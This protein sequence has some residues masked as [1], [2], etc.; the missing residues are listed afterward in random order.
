MR[1]FIC[2]F[3]LLFLSI[4]LN[5]ALWG[6]ILELGK[7]ITGLPVITQ[8]NA[9]EVGRVEDLGINIKLGTLEGIIIE[10]GTLFRNAKFV[11]INDIVT[12][13]RDVVVITRP[14]AVIDLPHNT[15]QD[16]SW[17]QS[18][19]KSIITTF[20]TDIGIIKDVIIQFPDGKI[21][22]IEI[23]GGIWSD[24]IQGRKIIPLNTVVSGEHQHLIVDNDLENIWL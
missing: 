24:L 23:S 19:G 13:G 21:V 11:S 15:L 20:G 17:Q 4:I 8:Q 7:H 3:F 12:V 5:N 1:I 16:Y 2:A 9:K 6:C 22:G 14:E 10:N 18:I